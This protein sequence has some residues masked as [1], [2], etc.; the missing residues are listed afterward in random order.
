MPA[1]EFYNKIGGAEKVIKY[2]HDLAWE[3]GTPVIIRVLVRP[4]LV[5][6][7]ELKRAWGTQFV[8]SETENENYEQYFGNMVAIALPVPKFST[9]RILLLLKKVSKTLTINSLLG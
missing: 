7:N 9:V 6:A 3:A 2:C 4:N 5:L 8:V 1:L